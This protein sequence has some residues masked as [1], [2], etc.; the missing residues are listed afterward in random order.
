MRRGAGTLIPPAAEWEVEDAVEERVAPL[1]TEFE[2]E[3]PL[4]YLDREGTL[5]RKGVMRLATA[6]DEL[7]MLYDARVRDRPE[8]LTVVLLGAVVTKLGTLPKVDDDVIERLFAADLAFLQDLYRRINQE[9]HTRA[10]VCCPS[11]DHEF[12]VDVAGGRQG[13]S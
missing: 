2:F 10:A 4:G 1:R 7:I 3:L 11:C 9:G 6:R 8:W 13:G 12:T 5:H